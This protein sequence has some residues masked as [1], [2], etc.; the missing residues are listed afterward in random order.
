MTDDPANTHAG[1]PSIRCSIV[2]REFGDDPALVTALLGLEPSRSGSRGDAY[3]NV[4]GKATGRTI[5]E[6][7]WSL[8]ST[9][10]P[11]DSLTAHATDLLRQ[12]NAVHSRFASL[13]SGTRV[14][15][16]ATVI[17]NGD[18]PLF[19]ISG[20]I[21]DGLARLRCSIEIDVVSVSSEDE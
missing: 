7:Y 20:E 9:A 21:I 11:R 10:S 4:L 17:P 8:H 14:S 3:R 15:L 12:T 18:L 13:P 19:E 1:V 6:S 2:I 5:R 16:R